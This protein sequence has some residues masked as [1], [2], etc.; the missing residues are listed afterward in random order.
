MPGLA[1]HSS[2]R[3][4]SPRFPSPSSA[5]VDEERAGKQENEKGEGGRE[6]KRRDKS[7]P[8]TETPK[9]KTPALMKLAYP[10]PKI[11]RRQLPQ[12]FQHAR[13]RFAPPR[14]DRHPPPVD[15]DF[16][17]LERKVD[18]DA[19]NADASRECRGQR[20]VVLKDNGTLVERMNNSLS[21]SENTPLTIDRGIAS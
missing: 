12:L 21:L 11:L 14:V 9:S 10:R 5:P 18:D 8:S 17:P 2:P 3:F 4:S 1:H 6:T 13:R 15:L 16:E 7:Q 19:A 20:K